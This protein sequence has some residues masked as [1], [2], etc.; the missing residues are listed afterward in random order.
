MALTINGKRTGA[1]AQIDRQMAQ[2]EQTEAIRLAKL[3]FGDAL[4]ELK[5]ED[6]EWES[7]YD[8][9]ENIPE[10]ICWESRS[11]VD[12]IIRRIRDRIVQVTA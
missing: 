11:Q 10:E 7:W 6:P 3:D 8:D 4:T 9:N 5:Q 1:A 12:D 2:F